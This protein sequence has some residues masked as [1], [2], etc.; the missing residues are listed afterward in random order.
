MAQKVGFI[1]LGAMGRPF[2]INILRA[3]FDLI[4]Y[5]V[6]P[7]PMAELVRLGAKSARSAREVAQYSEIVDIAVREEGDRSAGGSGGSKPPLDV[8]MHGPDGLLAGAHPGLAVVIHTVV[9]PLK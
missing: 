5:D 6:R 1:G 4:V 8:V 7:E 3:G 9:D 2:A